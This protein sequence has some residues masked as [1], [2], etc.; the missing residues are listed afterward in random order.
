MKRGERPEPTWR[1][2][3]RGSV[4]RHFLKVGPHSLRHERRIVFADLPVVTAS[5]QQVGEQA[6]AM[7]ERLKTD[8]VIL[9]VVAGC[10]L[11]LLLV[12]L[13]AYL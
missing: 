9:Y 2:P 6:E 13:G 3:T 11:L 7:L 12:V 10:G 8:P 1:E 4:D 5:H